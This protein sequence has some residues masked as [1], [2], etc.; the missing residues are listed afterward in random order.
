VR[1]EDAFLAVDG[2]GVWWLNVAESQISLV[3]KHETLNAQAVA[4]FE[5]GGSQQRLLQLPDVWRYIL[6]ALKSGSLPFNC[7]WCTG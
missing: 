1:G 5:G 2:D 3:A 4:T 6:A 7:C